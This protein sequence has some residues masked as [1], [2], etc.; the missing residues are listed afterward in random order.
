MKIMIY[1]ATLVLGLG[2]IGCVQTMEDNSIPVTK[3]KFL[4]GHKGKKLNYDVGIKVSADQFAPLI[5]KKTRVPTGMSF[6]MGAS[7]KN[8]LPLVDIAY[9]KSENPKEIVDIAQVMI[10]PVNKGEV[11]SKLKINLTVI[12]GWIRL[13]AKSTDKTIAVTLSVVKE[14]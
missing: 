6:E 9:L 13:D 1:I 2:L 14:Y 8:K 12:D 3:S 4:M 5:A 7:S 10:S 11:L